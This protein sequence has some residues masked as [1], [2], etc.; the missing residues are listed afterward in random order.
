LVILLPAFFGQ[1]V[2]VSAVRKY[3]LLRYQRASLFVETEKLA[4]AAALDA[5]LA[6][7]VG[8]RDA[9][10]WRALDARPLSAPP[11]TVRGQLS[12]RKRMPA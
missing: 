11:A 12:L 5:T 6:D 8:Y 1:Y 4:L 2:A 3:Q 7:F 9:L 10:A